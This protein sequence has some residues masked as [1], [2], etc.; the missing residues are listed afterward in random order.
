METF[1]KSIWAGLCIAIGAILFLNLG[2]VVGAFLFSIGL[3]TILHF[4][5]K[6]Y[7]GVIGYATT[8]KELPFILTVIIGNIIGCCLMFAFPTAA[9][10]ALVATKLA[11]PIWLVF[12]KAI[13]CGILIYVGVEAFKEDR[14][15]ITILAVAAFILCGAEHSI[16]DICFFISARYFSFES[17]IFIIVAIIGNAIGSLLIHNL[18][19]GKICVTQD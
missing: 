19:E 15:Y 4:K 13:I 2:G 17:L 6:L 1:I 9:A 7:T 18:K 16:A 10:G 12:I 3:L 8:Y 14:W 11:A 5:F